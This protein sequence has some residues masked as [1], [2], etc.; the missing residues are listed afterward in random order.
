MAGWRIA[1]WAG[2]VVL[3]LVFL[4][5]VRS[6]LLP[7]V[8]AG[9]TA[10]LLDPYIRKLRKRGMSKGGAIGVVFGAFSVVIL[11]LFVWLTPLV[12]TQ[13]TNLRTTVEKFSGAL[14]GPDPNQNF[15]VR[16]NPVVIVEAPKRQDV[17]DQF[18]T[19]LQ[20]TLTSLGLPSTRKAIYDRYVA[21]NSKQIAS[22]IQNFFNGFFGIIGNL[23]SQVVFLLMTPIILMMILFDM[24]HLKRRGLAWIP[25]SIRAGTV[26]ILDDIMNVVT[27]YIRGMM[28][29]T[30]IYMSVCSLILMIMGVPYGLLLGILFGALSLIPF[31]GQI[32]IYLIILT[33]CFLSGR[34]QL[35]FITFP[36]TVWY[37]II[38]FGLQFA[39][40]RINETFVYPRVVG[41]AVGLNPLVSMFVI[42]AGGA[43]FGLPGM[44]LAFPMAGAAKVILD[45]L[46]RVATIQGEVV[47]LPAVP[48]RHRA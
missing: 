43:L 44:I 17:V 11:G 24:D 36:S 8:L 5:L 27:N 42:F 19:D 33:V 39:W 34:E 25:P 48:A 12:G 14:A 31:V 30:L 35:L 28:M 10:I 15:F 16:W 37:A 41:K 20:P 9:I 3:S 7:F 29:Q 46:L 40:D 23:T 6:V 2:L 26:D 18:L 38:V 4:Y 13:I 1:L 22:A 21:P 47:A 45:R 32:V